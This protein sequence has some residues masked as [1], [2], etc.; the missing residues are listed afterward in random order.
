[1]GEC[2]TVADLEAELLPR[3]NSQGAR[4]GVR[5]GSLAAQIGGVHIRYLTL[6]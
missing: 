4:G 2:Q 1:M 5:L 6:E 3:R